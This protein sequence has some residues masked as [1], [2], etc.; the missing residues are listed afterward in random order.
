MDKVAFRTVYNRTKK[1]RKD[2]KALVQIELYVQGCKKY[3]TTAIYIEPPMWDEKKGILKNNAPNSIIYNKEIKDRL[4]QFEKI[5]DTLKTNGK[6][7][8]I[9]PLKAL[10]IIA[11][12]EQGKITNSFISFYEKELNGLKVEQ[13]TKGMY[14]TTLERLKLYRDENK[15]K[16]I[17]F[18]DITVDFLVNFNEYLRK[19]GGTNTTARHFSSLTKFYIDAINKDLIEPNKNPFKKYKV[20]TEIVNR[21]YLTTE[22][23]KQL[24]DLQLDTKNKKLQQTLD[25]FL[26]SCY[27]GLRISDIQRL[28]TD[29]FVVIDGEKCLFIEMKKTGKKNLKLEYPLTYF[30]PRLFS[31]IEKYSNE[32]RDTIFST[33]NPT[34]LSEHVREISKL[35]GINK[36]FT[37]HTSRH[38]CATYMLNKGVGIEIVSKILG[39]STIATTQI[40]AKMNSK[41]INNALQKVKL[42]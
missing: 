38:T 28:K 20:S 37:F 9:T 16:D 8:N 14:K 39:H 12:T 26:L 13:S 7:S 27:I 17:Y 3:V 6:L 40:Y 18:D 19:T 11:E 32:D 4:A 29:N 36:D 2:S 24:E 21:V 22:E 34:T 15:L 41:G 42:F 5:W 10:E 1:L 35:A 31:I 30:N 33:V 25:K 23:F